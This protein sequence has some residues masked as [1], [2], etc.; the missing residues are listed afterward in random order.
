MQPDGIV[1]CIAP[2]SGKNYRGQT[3]TLQEGKQ[4]FR[5]RGGNFI[6]L[7]DYDQ[8]SKQLPWLTAEDYAKLAASLK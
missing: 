2:Y 1:R 8:P 5:T 6:Y 4:Y 3:I 7:N